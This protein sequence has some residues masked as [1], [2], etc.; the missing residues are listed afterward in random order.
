MKMFCPVCESES[1]RN[2]LILRQINL[3]SAVYLCE[4]RQCDYP[5][6]HKWIVVERS[7]EEIFQHKEFT[8][9]NAERNKTADAATD[10]DIDSWLN[11]V[12][13]KT[14]F[15]ANLNMPQINNRDA[16]DL[17]EFDRFLNSA[18]TGN[19]NTESLSESGKSSCNLEELLKDIL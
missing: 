11:G 8:D 5:K 4:D 3:T 16:L 18:D 19:R 13:D 7:L 12:I 15:N 14:T 17:E 1:R 2:K 6:G 10:F 9:V